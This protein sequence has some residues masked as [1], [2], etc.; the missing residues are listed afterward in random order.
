MKCIFVIFAV[1]I[2]C[3][4]CGSAV[5]NPNVRPTEASE[6]KDIVQEYI[7]WKPLFETARNVSMELMTLCRLMTKQEEAYL[8]SEHGQRFVQVY[9]N[10]IAA[11]AITVVGKR[12]FPEGSVIV[13]EKW[14]RDP[15][16]AL[17]DKNLRPI[18]QG[19]MVKR[20]KS[21]NAAS[22]DWEYMYVDETGTITRDQ[23][24]LQH[25]IA[26]HSANQTGDSIFYT[27]SVNQ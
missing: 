26:C 15:R 20:G 23:T 18:G 6:A 27:P 22:G 25:C 8:G 9:A 14:D 12:V 3:A 5:T 11:P 13:K 17:N 1:A 19:I 21:F 4:G 7:Q 16:L 10:P 24:Q 2:F